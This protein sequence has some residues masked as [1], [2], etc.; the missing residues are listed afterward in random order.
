[1]NY[2]NMLNKNVGGGQI[3]YGIVYG[4]EKI[5]FIKS[6]SNGK[7]NGSQNKYLKMA[8]RIHDRIGATVICAS[9]PYEEI[10]KHVAIDKSLI[11]YVADLC[12]FEKYELYFVGTSDGGYI[13]LLLAKQFSETVKY[14]GINSSHRGL[15]R[16]AKNIQSI[17]QVEKIFVYGTD[18]EDFDSIFSMLNSLDCE[19]L[20]IITLDGIDHHFTNRVDDFINLIDII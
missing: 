12:N 5:V 18:D 2:D 11:K 16:L 1:M 20:K 13:S 4:N 3:H 19:N 9:N 7:I 15:E 17:P 14:L 8:H 10:P 6:G